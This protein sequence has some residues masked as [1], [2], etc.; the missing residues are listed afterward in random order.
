[1]YVACLAMQIVNIWSFVRSL[2][3]VF[4]L[5]SVQI[6]VGFYVAVNK[7]CCIEISLI[8]KRELEDID[9]LIIILFKCINR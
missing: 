6:C 5:V 4:I 1:M 7:W 8:S 2:S 9:C 3:A